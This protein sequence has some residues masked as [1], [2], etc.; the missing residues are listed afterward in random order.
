MKI[1]ILALTLFCQ[2]FSCTLFAQV[3]IGISTPNTS[4]QLDVTSTSKG[5]LPPRMTYSQRS[6]IVSPVA[7]LMVWCS[8]CGSNG[9]Y[10]GEMQVYNG[11]SWTN[12]IGGAANGPL[13]IGSTY[14]GG[15]V[16]YFLQNGDPGYSATVQHGLIVSTV[17]LA[18]SIQWYNGS[19]MT[20]GA[21]ATAIGSGLANTNSIISAQ[22]ASSSNYAAGLARSY[23]GGGYNDWYLPSKDE[24]SKLYI[25]RASIGS[26]TGNDYW[27]SSE[28][29][30]NNAYVQNITSGLQ[31]MYIKESLNAVRAIR[32]F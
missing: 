6:A 28:Y 7:G 21:S 23:N 30:S 3:G 24:F 16:F 31:N 10:N 22:G 8:N 11:S 32:A 4:A 26:F 25:N 19:Y 17:D 18:T 27:T 14:Q 12:M 5:F 13:V 1:Q 15:K 29:G 20:T 9:V 2:L